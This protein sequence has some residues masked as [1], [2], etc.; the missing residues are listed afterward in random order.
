MKNK[1]DYKKTLTKIGKSALIV[2]LTGLIVILT[3]KP[4]FLALIPLVEGLLNY[5]KH[6]D[7]K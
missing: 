4:E 5:V 7:D 3:E 1:Y 6:K 2:F